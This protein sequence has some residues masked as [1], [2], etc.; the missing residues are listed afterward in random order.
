MKFIRSR[1]LLAN[2]RRLQ[3]HLHELRGAD[4]QAVSAIDVPVLQRYK[5]NLFD[6][7]AASRLFGV[8][9]RQRYSNLRRNNH[10]GDD[11]GSEE[12]HQHRRVS[13]TLSDVIYR[14]MRRPFQGDAAYARYMEKIKQKYQKYVKNIL[15]HNNVRPLNY[16]SENGRD[17]TSGLAITTES[18]VGRVSLNSRGHIDSSPLSN[19]DDHSRHEFH[20]NHE[21]DNHNHFDSNIFTISRPQYQQRPVQQQHQV[22]NFNYRPSKKQ[23]NEELQHHQP[24]HSNHQ[25]FYNNTYHSIHGGHVPHIFDQNQFSVLSNQ[26]HHGGGRPFPMSEVSPKSLRSNMT[27]MIAKLTAQIV[28][29]KRSA[30]D[31][32]GDITGMGSGSTGQQRV[33]GRKNGRRNLNATTVS[34]VAGV[35]GSSTAAIVDTVPTAGTVA[36]PVIEVDRDLDELKRGKPKSPCEV[37]YIHFIN[38]ALTLILLFCD[39]PSHRSRT[40]VLT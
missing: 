32:A 7:S 26:N 8:H 34:T 24:V 14:Q 25:A 37:S 6:E 11:I 27:E 28:R 38:L 2:Y 16:S 10:N 4:Y 35:N 15:G 30:D 22:Y 31:D 36:V 21:Q 33:G 39:R 29:R 9:K 3:R 18:N 5:R 17:L 19:E 13:R 1:Y 12:D 40:C 20:M 23:K